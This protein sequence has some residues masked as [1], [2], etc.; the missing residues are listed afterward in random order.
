MHVKMNK[1]VIKVNEIV[2]AFHRSMVKVDKLQLLQYPFVDD[3]NIH[4][5]QVLLLIRQEYSEK[6]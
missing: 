6:N 1:K 4:N 2:I 3:F 5:M